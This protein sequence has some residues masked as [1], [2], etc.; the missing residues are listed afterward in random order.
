MPQLPDTS[1]TFRVAL[2]LSDSFIVAAQVPWI[3]VHGWPQPMHTA[4]VAIAAILEKV[5]F[6]LCASLHL[7][8]TTELER[9]RSFSFN[10][11]L[12]ITHFA[13]NSENGKAWTTDSRST[14][15]RM[16]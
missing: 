2:V 11:V 16:K 15:T 3:D 10:L 8:S 9:R 1:A 12:L 4:T 7:N 6:I 14:G 13:T 5:R